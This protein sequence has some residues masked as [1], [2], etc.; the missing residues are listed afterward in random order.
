MAIVVEDGS[1]VTNANSYVSEAELSTYADTRGIT[2]SD[3][4]REKWLI[5]AMDYL[6]TLDFIGRKQL[7]TQELQWPRDRV[8]IDR[9]LLDEGVIP[10]ELKN[11]QMHL[12]TS[13][14]QGISPS[15]FIQRS[16][17]RRK[18]GDLEIEYMDGSS[19]LVIDRKLKML[20]RKIV[21]GGAGGRSYVVRK[22]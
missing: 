11:A 18:V 14:A 8:Y 13:I 21:I 17:K 2:I 22:A 4:D 16:V 19:S 3:S 10:D 12:A 15:S 7:E 1:V 9:Y 20:L 6:E 5:L